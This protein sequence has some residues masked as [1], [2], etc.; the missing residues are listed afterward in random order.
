M[1]RHIMTMIKIIMSW[2]LPWSWSWRHDDYH[3]MIITSWWSS[4]HD[5]DQDHKVMMVIMIMI[6][7][8]LL[9]QRSERKM[10]QSQPRTM[11]YK[12]WHYLH[13]YNKKGDIFEIMMII[14]MRKWMN[15]RGLILME[16]INWISQMHPGLIIISSIQ[17]R[18]QFNKWFTFTLHWL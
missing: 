13:V 10:L 12:N 14:C 2:W 1:W 15:E 6:M 5:H 7:I 9:L 3:I 16:R 8:S 11:F 4:H 17:L 18:V